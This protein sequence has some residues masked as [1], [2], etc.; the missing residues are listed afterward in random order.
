[1][2]VEERIKVAFRSQLRVGESARTTPEAATEVGVAEE[3]LDT[4]RE[5][6]GI[7]GIAHEAAAGLR[8]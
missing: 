1:M 8:S 2:D 4:L 3:E 7:A 5:T 6:R